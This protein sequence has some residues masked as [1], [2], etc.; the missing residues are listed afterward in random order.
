M[1]ERPALRYAPFKDGRQVSKAHSTPEA[2]IAE[3]YAHGV[4]VNLAADFPGDTAR[5][6][7]LEQGYSARDVA[8][9]SSMKRY[10]LD[11]EKPQRLT[12]EEESRLGKTA[13]DYSDVPPLGEE[14]FSQA[15]PG[16]EPNE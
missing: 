8:R 1:S 3:A 4:V 13:I 15:K 12:P 6:K 14:F 10:R 11:P 5:Q 7:V 16:N 2:A 9:G